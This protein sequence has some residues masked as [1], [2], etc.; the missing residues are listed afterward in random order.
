MWGCFRSRRL[1]METVSSKSEIDARKTRR[2]VSA[3]KP[4]RS[5]S[6]EIIKLYVMYL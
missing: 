6:A 3:S 5:R 2:D 1:G 4:T